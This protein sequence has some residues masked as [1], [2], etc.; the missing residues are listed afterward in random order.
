MGTMVLVDTMVDTTDTPTDTVSD[1]VILARDLLMPNLKLKLMPML[2]TT[3]VDTM[4]I[5]TDTDMVLVD[6]M[7]T[8]DTDT[9][10][11][12]VTLARDPLMPNPKLMLLPMP[13]MVTT[14]TVWDTVDTV[15]DTVDTVAVL[16]VTTVTDGAS[17]FL[18]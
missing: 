1:T 16:M 18:T 12:T 11:D 13:T 2:L 4:A 6:T 14:D 15:W 7:D 17:R 5:P 9:V 10:W 3:M 8:A